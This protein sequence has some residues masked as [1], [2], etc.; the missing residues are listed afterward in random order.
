MRVLIVED[1]AIVAMH[2]A[3]LVAQLGHV[4]CAVVSSATEAV[5]RAATLSPDVVLMDIRLAGAAAASKLLRSFMH[6]RRCAASFSAPTWMRRLKQH[7]C[8]VT[9]STSLESLSCRSGCCEHCA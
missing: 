3:M 4:V 5:A 7:C 9:P 1:D 6:A 2:L 8:L